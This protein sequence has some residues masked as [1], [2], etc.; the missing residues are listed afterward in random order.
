MAL[1]EMVAAAVAVVV[2]AAVAVVVAAAG[3]AVLAAAVAAGDSCQIGRY[4]LSCKKQERKKLRALTS[5]ASA[6]DILDDFL[7]AGSRG[8]GSANQSSSDSI[9]VLPSWPSLNCS[10]PKDWLE[11][12]AITWSWW[13]SRPG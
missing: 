9:S 2:A 4:K 12:W 6:S 7:E 13:W 8:C 11:T 1:T 5:R 10:S 3:A